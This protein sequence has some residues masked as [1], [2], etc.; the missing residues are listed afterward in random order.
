MEKLWFKLLLTTSCSV[1]VL[2]LSGCGAAPEM[3]GQVV[4]A[5][6]VKE[7][8]PPKLVEQTPARPVGYYRKL[9]LD[10]LQTP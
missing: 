4:E 3:P 9:V 1:L 8:E 6:Q 2:C 7:P 10:A 5:P